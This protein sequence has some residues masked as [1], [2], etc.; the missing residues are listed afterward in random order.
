MSSPVVTKEFWWKFR[1]GVTQEVAKARQIMSQAAD[2]IR[3]EGSKIAS[4]GED[5]E[6]VGDKAKEAAQD[7]SQAVSKA[8][9]NAESMKNS[10]QNAAESIRGQFKKT[11][12]VIN[13]IPKEKAFNLKAKF[14]DD[15]LKTFSRKIN[16][17]P[18]QKSIW[19][20]I[21]DGFSNSLHNVQRQADNTKRSFST[22]KSVMAGTFVG[23]A[24][25]GGIYAIGNGLKMAAGAGMEFDTE[26]QKMLA[27]WKTLTGSAGS[28]KGMV[29]TINDLSIKTGQATDTINELEQGF[30]HL[31]SSK[32]E[33]DQM[34]TA[35][36]NMG[37]AVGLS[38]QQL[39]QVE[40]D[41][42]H[43][44]ATGKVTQGELNQIGMYFPMIDEQM[45]KHFHTTVA[46]MRKMA[47]AG[48][49]TGKDLEEVFEKMGN[50]GK[51][52][53]AVDNM[54]Q[55]TWGSM[56]TIKSMVPR[57]VGSMEQGL[58][59]AKN[60]LVS[61]IAKWTTDPATKKG[62]ENFGKGISDVFAGLGSIIV[63][64]VKPF[65]G[66]NRIVG[67]VLKQFASGVW[68]GMKASFET[69][70]VAVKFISDM[71]SGLFGWVGKLIGYIGKITGLS[72]AFKGTENVIKGFG[73]AVGAV[74]GPI[75]ALRGAIAAYN[76]VI[77]AYTAATKIAS[78][79][80]KLFAGANGLLDASLLANP[81][82]WIVAGVIALGV[83]FYEAYKHIKPF[84]DIVNKTGQ[85]IKKFFTGK[86]GWEKAITKEFSN[87]G[88]DIRKFANS[89]P[90]FFKNVGKVLGKLFKGFGKLLLYS[91]ALPVGAAVIITRPLVKP[92]ERIFK[93]LIKWIQNAW[94]GLV[95]FLEPIFR[96][97]A[98]AW[99]VVW[100]G[101]RKTFTTIWNGLKKIA[102]V[103]MQGIERLISPG[104]KAIA[105]VWNASWKAIANFFSGIWNVIRAVGGAGIGALSGAISGGLN[106][107]SGIWHSVWNSISSFFRGIWN[108]IKQAAQDG[109][110]GVINVIN[111]GIG[112]I[113]KVWS[114]F[115]G[116]GTG[117]K[118]LGHVHFAQG[119]TVHRH[120]SV[121]NDGDGP[122]WKELVQ[123]PDGN[124]FMSQ[125]RNWT[126]F[127][128]E[129]TRVYSGAET[130]QIMNAVG[131]SHY[132]TGGI[133][134]AQH[135]AD[136][137]IIGEGIDWAKGSL[138][139][140]G[141]WLGDKLD[142]IMDFLGDPLKATKGLLE[143]A[144][145]GLYKGLGNFADVAHGAMDKLTQPISDWFKKN[146]EPI[147]DKL[148]ES[149]PGGAGVARWEPLIKRAAKMEGIALTPTMLHK[150]LTQ[151]NTESGGNPGAI[152][153][154][155][156]LADGHATG[157]LQF[158]P[159]TFRSWIWHGH[160]NIMNGF[161]QIL[162]AFNALQHGGE[163]G[164]GSFGIPGRGWAT[165]GE[166]TSQMFGWVGD[167]PE[168]HEFILNPYAVS[169]EPLLDKAFEATAQ[170][171]PATQGSVN[172]GNSKLDQMIDLL[173]KVLVAIESQDTNVYLDGEKIT[174]DTNKR[175]AKTWGM[176]K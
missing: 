166:I 13:G 140:L 84:R 165:G 109:M 24:V 110:N 163:G 125:E 25:L 88:K 53:H 42:V 152:G 115:T 170:A 169:A 5:W 16:D 90:K 61:A 134:G 174:D 98:K 18:E 146:L 160:G 4:T 167:N 8:K 50:S 123:T 71:L 55:T 17:I 127:L 121:I 59:K 101:I 40:Q 76:T 118:E 95:R 99:S 44:L 100:N 161:D 108:G 6:K 68:I 138:E 27:T 176:I 126:G 85:A 142:A 113:N 148:E 119:G 158:K 58:F 78:A 143:K 43:G 72:N 96:P 30:Y 65:E 151:I 103:G 48:K 137:G 89:I 159:R 150:M 173:G 131:V 9:E 149:N 172:G 93:A 19:L 104:V 39:T 97:I 38:G 132:A 31:H 12:E 66:F 26:Q 155:D 153:G 92:I 154:T 60:P 130:R 120:L 133:V 171:Q 164:W 35:M 69:M 21:K 75:V 145:S 15:K 83:A 82:T 111:A 52:K 106:A 175:N 139:N 63:N 91:L 168:H 114:F 47:T 73:S 62:F 70:G 81:I 49:I 2:E 3:K 102:Q 22:L 14:D 80:S 157:L 64:L 77:Y 32:S 28:A 128:P 112:G 20:K 34:T 51:Y 117:V 124:L 87:V 129:G 107:I 141:S 56:R 136:G 46:G 29:D 45:A 147:L 67:A 105:R 23:G 86:L 1:D 33:A 57:L 10:A 74:L 37:D 162:A 144:T 94:K 7:T 11:T 54:M 135:F 36:L 41:M 116:H 79:A 156:G 122:D